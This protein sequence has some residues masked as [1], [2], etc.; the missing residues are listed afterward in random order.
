MGESGKPWFVLDGTLTPWPSPPTGGKQPADEIEIPPEPKPAPPAAWDEI[1]RL[2]PEQI[3]RIKSAPQPVL[4]PM[5]EEQERESVEREFAARHALGGGKPTV[6][7]HWEPFPVKELPEPCRRFVTAAAAAIG[8]D[9]AYI[10]LPLLSALA[11]AVGNARSIRLDEDWHEPAVVWSALVGEGGTLKSPALDITLEP[12]WKQQVRDLRE[13]ERALA[14]A[15]EE[16]EGGEK[17][18]ESDASCDTP[19]ENGLPVLASS[20]VPPCRRTIVSKVTVEALEQILSENPRGV[21]L[22][23]DELSGWLAS[24]D[25]RRGGVGSDAADWLSMFNARPL[26][27]DRA[28]GLRKIVYIPRAAVSVTGGVQPEVL[29][30]AL[31][32]G[33]AQEGFG[34]RLLMAWPPRRDRLFVRQPM[35]AKIRQEFADLLRTLRDLQP[36][37]DA[38]GEPVPRALPLVGGAEMEWFAFYRDWAFRQAGLTGELAAIYAKLECYA[39]RLALLIHLVRRASGETTSEGV[40]GPSLRSGL[41]LAYWFAAEAHRIA[42][43]FA[44]ATNPDDAASRLV[45][46]IENRGGRVTV[47]DL[48]HNVRRYRVAKMAE[49][50]LNAL[51]KEGW[52]HWDVT[53]TDGR[54][55][56]E[57]VLDRIPEKPP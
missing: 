5:T 25:A 37:R 49:A 31:A 1:Y 23:R 47:R 22:A 54:P 16:V 41:K 26:L 29:K 35:P 55:R 18:E 46:W 17:S 2:T 12:L 27:I 56:T 11:G 3:E 39:A 38:D 43:L 28:R 30:A 52:G 4:A 10:A 45:E 15:G 44:G 19:A 9:E 6:A 14:A 48:T 21:L 32:R 36:D 24:F 40:D 42:A 34:A 53:S 33:Q 57:F 8:C 7:A 50:A 51:V 13:H 20:R